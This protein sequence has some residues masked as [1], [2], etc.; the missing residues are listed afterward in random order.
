V[1]PELAKLEAAVVD[2]PVVVI[3]V[4]AAKFATE[5]EAASVAAAVRRHR[6]HHPVVLDPT[7]RLWDQYAIRS[8]PT[9]VVLDAT[10]RVAWQ[11][12]GEVTHEELLPVV[13]RLVEEA[14]ADG[15]LADAAA[16]RPDA[17]PTVS[18]GLSFPGKLHVWPDLVGQAH[19]RDPLA[20]GR[21]YVADTGNH[22]ILELALSRGPDG[23]P[24]ATR[25]R[26]FGGNGPG[27]VDG[28]STFAR[29]HAPQG[30]ARAGDTLWV[31]DTENHALRTVDLGSGEVRTVAGTG[32]LGRGGAP[33]VPR[34]TALRSPWD[35][36]VSTANGK[37]EAVFVAMAGT[38]QLWVH[39]VEQDRIGPLCG[40]GAEDHVDGAPAEAALAQPSGLSLV[41]RY[42]FFADSEVSS[43]R[44]FDLAEHRV[45]TLVGKGLFDFGDVDGGP[46][47]A[48]LQHPLAVAASE[49]ELYVADTFNHKI[50]AIDLRGGDLRTVAG[51]PGAL[52]EPGG[53][54]LAADFLLVADTNHH[55]VR[56][57]HRGTGE[58]RDVPIAG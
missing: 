50:K 34:K 39:L 51:G 24:V 38:H 42:L 22:R 52:A 13:R 8:W 18:A 49:G 48:L 15:I 41:G 17:P 45:G 3:G 28:P 16:W 44:V 27:L 20:D 32:R 2:E 23:W 36:A 33:D 31:A 7:H 40:S 10:G 11:K 35:V 30:L 58:L 4:H 29:F 43:V 12:A 47:E 9:V 14:R 55:R 46:E 5:R 25:L 6:V 19:G 53:L 54:A 21:L 57:M 1:L 26:T 37:A 56:A